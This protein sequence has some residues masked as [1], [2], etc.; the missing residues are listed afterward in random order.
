M[1]TPSDDY[2]LHQ[3]A[4]PFAYAGTD[5]NFYDRFF[6]NGYSAD[7]AV[8]FACALGVYPQLNIMDASFCL[9]LDGKQYNL[10][11]SREMTGDRLDLSLGPIRLV[12][13]KPLHR[14][15]LIVAENEYGLSAD[16]VATARHAAIEEPR[17][18]QRQGAR[19]QMDVTRLTQNIDWQGTLCLNG[20]DITVEGCRGTR[21]RSWGLRP[22]GS[23]DAQPTVPPRPQQFFWLWTPCNF[24]TGCFFFHSNDYADGSAWNRHIQF[25]D[26]AAKSRT[27]IADVEFDASYHQGTRRVKQLCVKAG[28]LSAR[29]TP[30]APVFYM[31]GLGYLNP[32]W[33]HG[34]HHGALEVGFDV[35]DLDEA[36]IRLKAGAIEHIHIQALADVEVSGA[37]SLQ[38]GVGVI[39]QLLIG[40]HA[41]SGFEDVFDKVLGE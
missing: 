4:E 26:F 38:K 6:F 36:E 22:I 19:V 16:L 18:T 13:E 8:F 14:T 5:R 31:T 23:P 2:P 21:D 7:G 30:R 24:D 37:G 9:S 32:T 41:P 12:I 20:Q 28:A 1:I 34:M 29:L 25:D 15:R 27:A 40:P 39:E 3:T 11:A 33:G 17:F 35:L 10:R